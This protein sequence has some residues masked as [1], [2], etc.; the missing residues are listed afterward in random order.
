M[1]IF[2]CIAILKSYFTKEV[3]Y[4]IGGEYPRLLFLAAHLL[5]AVPVRTTT[6]LRALRTVGNVV[7]ALFAAGADVLQNNPTATE[8]HLLALVTHTAHLRHMIALLPALVTLEVLTTGTV[9][10]PMVAN[11]SATETLIISGR[12]P[13]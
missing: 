6:V 2:N 9:A 5:T 13:G 4:N 3:N 1:Y 7:T 10:R 12:F 8:V 11:F